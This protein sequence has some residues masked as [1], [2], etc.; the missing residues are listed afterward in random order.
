MADSREIWEVDPASYMEEPATT[1]KKSRIQKLREMISP[2]EALERTGL[3]N[4]GSGETVGELAE[5]AARTAPYWTPGAGYILG[6]Q[7]VSHGWDQI[8][9]PRERSSLGPVPLPDAQDAVGALNMLGGTLDVGFEA[10]DTYLPGEWPA[11]AILWGL[12]AHRVKNVD[13]AIDAARMAGRVADMRHA[14][15]MAD[16]VTDVARVADDIPAHLDDTDKALFRAKR[17]MQDAG[18]TPEDFIGDRRTQRATEIAKNIAEETGLYPDVTG[19]WMQGVSDADMRLLTPKERSA[20]RSEAIAR[21]KKL[22]DE[23]TSFVDI[24]ND[25]PYREMDFGDQYEMPFRFP[26]AKETDQFG[27]PASELVDFRAALKRQAKEAESVADAYGR[28]TSAY[29]SGEG[30]PLWS[31]LEHDEAYKAIPELRNI[32]FAYDPGLPDS[33]MGS[34]DDSLNRLRL[35]P[36]YSGDELKMVLGHELNHAA[37]KFTGAPQGT[38]VGGFVNKAEMDK[39]RSARSMLIQQMKADGFDD[40]KIEAAKILLDDLSATRNSRDVLDVVARVTSGNPDWVNN[41]AELIAQ[42]SPYTKRAVENVLTGQAVAPDWA[43]ERRRLLFDDYTNRVG[44]ANSDAVGAVIKSD[45]SGRPRNPDGGD[46]QYIWDNSRKSTSKFVDRGTPSRKQYITR[47]MDAREAQHGAERDLIVGT[48]EERFLA[49]KGDTAGYASLSEDFVPERAA[50]SPPEPMS[51]P[52]DSNPA[53]MGAAPDFSGGSRQRFTTGNLPPHMRVIDEMFSDPSSSQ[54]QDMLERL[55]TGDAP[56]SRSFYNTMQMRDQFTQTLGDDLGR[57]AWSDTMDL[58]SQMSKRSPVPP[59]IKRTAMMRYMLNHPEERVPGT[60]LSWRE[61]MLGSTGIQDA[62]VMS[63]GTPKGL[64]HYGADAQNMGAFEWLRRKVGLDGPPNPRDNAK[65]MEY[66]LSKKGDPTA[67]V[68]DVHGT[69]DIFML[70]GLPEGLSNQGKIGK[71][72]REAI[73]AQFPNAE[74]MMAVNPKAKSQWIFR[75]RDAAKADPDLTSFLQNKKFATAWRDMPEPNE[76]EAMAEIFRRLSRDNPSLGLPYQTQAAQWFSPARMGQE[77]LK[78]TYVQT[79]QRLIREAAEREGISM[80]EAV[81][82]WAKGNLILGDGFQFG[83]DGQRLNVRSARQIEKKINRAPG[84]GNAVATYESIPS[85]NPRIDAGSVSPQEGE[86]FHKA[87]TKAW[88]GKTGKDAL[89]ESMGRDFVVDKT[90]PMQGVYGDQM[91]PGSAVNMRLRPEFNDAGIEVGA[92]SGRARSNLEGAEGLRAYLNMQEGAAASTFTRRPN[93]DVLPS[94]MLIKKNAGRANAKK[95]RRL[96]EMMGKEFGMDNVIDTNHGVISTNFGYGKMDPVPGM[97]NVPVNIEGLSAPI[98]AGRLTR[99][100]APA[101]IRKMAKEAGMPGAAHIG[102]RDGVYADY[103]GKWTN[104]GSGDATRNLLDIVSRDP[105]TYQY[106][107]GLDLSKNAGQMR[108]LVSDLARKHPGT[109]STT[110]WE[111]AMKIFEQ[112]PGALDRLKKALEAGAVSLP[113]IGLIIMGLS[114]DLGMQGD[115]ETAIQG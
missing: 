62:Q 106:L 89:Y 81:R 17:M 32:D 98:E 100:D 8:T 1:P 9:E 15:N 101:K 75:A 14:D 102:G 39:V 72:A 65:V 67:V 94:V 87:M 92:L 46:L 52:Q 4:R 44:E 30:V 90:L 13:D 25:R 47:V 88:E 104:P 28:S 82:E 55:R 114:P 71:K 26:G 68:L 83:K 108:E 19:H 53:W 11:L 35:N 112:G 2:M 54:Y 51:L 77:T 43:N 22:K 79:T 109:A 40:K 66:A 18:L 23:S 111:N 10:L 110:D 86:R 80:D 48:P 56:L 93:D 12:P 61:F 96:Q 37:A 99:A 6:P 41:N 105:V 42:A 78:E 5:A 34:F 69:R 91:N 16:A 29:G 7:Q 3:I 84:H 57:V 74:R 103:S 97:E 58:G 59:E 45:L 73:L 49:S 95:L 63:A 27:R 60:A 76:Y 107:N 33:T 21:W 38:F 31:V 85:N 70:A 36:A 113:A 20:R 24:Y 115:D 50:G 64:G